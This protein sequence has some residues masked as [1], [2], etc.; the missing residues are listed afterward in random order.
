MRKVL[1][2]LE[3]MGP[4]IG[5]ARHG[6]DF[7]KLTWFGCSPCTGCSVH[8]WFCVPLIWLL[9][10]RTKRGGDI[11]EREEV[12]TCVSGDR[13]DLQNLPIANARK[14]MRRVREAMCMLQIVIVLYKFFSFV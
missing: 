5:E 13:A 6:L 9:E 12:P 4:E 3:N 10:S 14:K 1:E 11:V 2:C 8:I 7:Q